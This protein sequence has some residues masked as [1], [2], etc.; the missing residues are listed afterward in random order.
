MACR[1]VILALE[2]VNYSGRSDEINVLNI[3][4]NKTIKHENFEK[5]DK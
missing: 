2:I 5:N 3:L 1:K 4:S